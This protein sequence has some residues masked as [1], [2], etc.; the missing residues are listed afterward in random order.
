M[1]LGVDSISQ[2]VQGR[3]VTS[4]PDYGKECIADLV[5]DRVDNFHKDG[6]VTGYTAGSFDL[7]T[8]N[9]VI[10]LTGMKRE[11]AQRADV[12]LSRTL[13]IVTLDTNDAIRESKSFNPDKGGCIKPILDWTTRASMLGLLMMGT[14][15]DKNY[16]PLVDFITAHGPCACPACIGN[17]CP[18]WDNALTGVKIQP[19]FAFVNPDSTA[20]VMTYKNAQAEG[21]LGSTEIVEMAESDDQFMDPLIGGPV[22]N[23]T[24]INRIIGKNG[25]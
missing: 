23:S 18:S 7:L 10:G 22:K 12:P 6:F 3:M 17:R 8:I 15:M 16:L 14:E 21:R 2:T 24:I 11:I 25:L 19:H 5:A 13:L 9:H 4:M 20:T 1:G